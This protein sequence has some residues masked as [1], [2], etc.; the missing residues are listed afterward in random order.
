M[1]YGCV[2]RVKNLQNSIWCLVTV[3]MG[4]KRVPWPTKSLQQLLEYMRSFWLGPLANC[5]NQLPWMEKKLLKQDAQIVWSS[6]QGHGRIIWIQGKARCFYDLLVDPGPEE[7]YYHR[8]LIASSFSFTM[9][10][11]FWAW[12]GTIMTKN[13]SESNSLIW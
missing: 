10:Y 1:F 5:K 12:S 3:H 8:V 11:F 9:S 13:W 7:W 2:A 6:K 4:V